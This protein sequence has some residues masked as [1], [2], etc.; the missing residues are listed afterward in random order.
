MHIEIL[1]GLRVAQGKA[2]VTANSRAALVLV[3][4]LL[5]LVLG[6]ACLLHQVSHSAQVLGG[7]IQELILDGVAGLALVVVAIAVD[8]IHAP[9]LGQGGIALATVLLGALGGLLH[10]G[11]K[12]FGFFLRQLLV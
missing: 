4:R 5:A 9:I 10:L 3:D 1:S 2:H 8:V 12:G 11:S 7:I 6:E